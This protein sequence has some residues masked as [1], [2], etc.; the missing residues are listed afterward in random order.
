MEDS[1]S[2]VLGVF[3]QLLV[4]VE[5]KTDI[6]NAITL[7]LKMEEWHVQDRDAN[8]IFLEPPI[9]KILSPLQ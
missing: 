2:G 8:G 4:E 5:P 9:K 6:D 3:V 7:Q 1:A